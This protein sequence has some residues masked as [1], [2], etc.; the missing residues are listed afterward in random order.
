MNQVY[1][2]VIFDEQNFKK[3][4]VEKSEFEASSFNNLLFEEAPIN[5][6]KFIDCQFVECDLSNCKMN[7]AS[8]RDVEFQNCKM[9]GVRW[10]TVNPLLFKTTFKSCILSHSSFLG[11]D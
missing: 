1:Y 4:I 5:L 8:F 2:N 9:L 3:N 10:D 6:S 11:M 7:M